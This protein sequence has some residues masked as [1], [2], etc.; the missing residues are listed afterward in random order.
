MQLSAG[1]CGIAVAKTA[2]AEVMAANGI[3]DIFIANE[4]VGR[5]KFERLAALS[6]KV[7]L[8]FGVDSAEAVR[9]IDDVFAAR[10]ATAR[11]L[12]EVETGEN[13]TG[14]T[15]VQ[16]MR[17]LAAALGQ[18]Q[19]VELLGVFSHEGFTYKARSREE[20]LLQFEQCQKRTLEF[21]DIVRGL[22]RSEP[23]VSVGA[24]PT[25][26]L[27]QSVLPGVTELRPGTYAL[28]DAAQGAA[29]GTFDRC[30]ASVL[31]TVISKPTGERVV[32]DVGAKGITAQTRPEG[33]CKTTGYGLV[34]NSD[35]ITA[36]SVYDEHM[37][38]NGQ[39][40]SD[41]VRIGDKIE[42]IPN[43]ICPVCNLYE[44]IILVEGGKI[45][46]SIPVACR[47]KLT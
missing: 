31:V 4:V 40:L 27:A 15:T 33:I 24:T 25:A 21:A 39:G 18:A 28:M 19:N 5:Q 41:L 6:K 13:R 16:G 26:W 11:L 1:A 2:E 46:G 32:C 12:I 9:Q 42:I 38:I 44:E 3:E 34:R 17:E 7:L 30:A 47:G 14:V 45:V 10:G 20:C 43:H 23:V 35:F 36:S 29:I 22:C 37:I 8:S